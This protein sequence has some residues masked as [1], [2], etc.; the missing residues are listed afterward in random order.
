MLGFS[1][2]EVS[3]W[4]VPPNNLEHAV[5]EK[6]LGLVDVQ[7]ANGRP[8]VFKKISFHVVPSSFR[9]VKDRAVNRLLFLDVEAEICKKHLAEL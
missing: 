8:V 4:N 9:K 1:F 3:L 6:L 5:M 7:N 2:D